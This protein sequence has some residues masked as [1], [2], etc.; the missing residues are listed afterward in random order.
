MKVLIA[1]SGGVDSSVAAKLITDKGYDCIGCTMKMYDNDDA[2]IP[3]SHTCCSL[4]DVE[5]ARGVAVKLG[6]PY[7]VFNFKDGFREKIIDEFASAY[8]NGMTPNPCISCNR[9]MKFGKLFERAEILGCDKIATGHYA[10]IEY[11]GEKYV[12]KKAIDQRKDQSYVLYAMT[13]RQLAHTLFPLGEMTKDEARRIARESSLSVADKADSQ[14]ICFVPNGNYAEI[15]ELHTG[16]KSVAGEF[17]DADGKVL[18][19]HKGI[20]YYTVGQHKGLGISLPGRK[21]VCKVDAKNNTVTLGDEND[22][23]ARGALVGDFNWISGEAPKSQI[24][25][26][27]KIRYRQAEVPAT[28]IAEYDGKVRITFDSPVRA[29]TPGQAAVV[30]DSDVVL[31]GGTIIGAIK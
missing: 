20:I 14:D 9:Y 6:M 25:C 17:V 31:G 4:D 22:L 21:Y 23:Y 5:D 27:V 8:M 12:L 29:V 10:R 15:I 2:G 7:Y 1:M 3:R 18:G 16:K 19:T 11:D 24:S 26:T 30:Y 13:Q 28:V